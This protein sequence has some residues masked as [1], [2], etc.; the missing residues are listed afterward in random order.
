M[1]GAAMPVVGMAKLEVG[2][3]LGSGPVPTGDSRVARPSILQASAILN[4]WV[5]EA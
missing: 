1:F 5:G 2:H 3:E 4:I